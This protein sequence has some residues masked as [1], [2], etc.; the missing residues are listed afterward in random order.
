MTPPPRRPS[1][2]LPRLALLLLPL[3]AALPAAAQPADVGQLQR[4]VESALL[5]LGDRGALGTSDE[6]LTVSSP[7]QVRYEL[8]AVLVP[9]ADGAPAIMAITPGGAAER[10]RLRVG[11]RLVSVNGKALAGVDEPVAALQSAIAADDGALR[12]E[13]LRAGKVQAATGS[14]GI[15]AIP[16][17]RLVVGAATTGACDGYVSDQGAQPR[18]HSIYA[19][20]ITRIDGRSTPLHPTNRHRVEPGRHVLTVRELVDRTWLNRAQVRTIDLMQRRERA[21][22]YKSLVVDVQPGTT[23]KI[24]AR[25]LRDK[26]DSESI[27][28][29]AY[30]EPVVWAVDPD[31]CH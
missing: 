5:A 20:D 25:L 19:A 30:W 31:P 14:A 17:Y 26:L 13:Y 6:P 22:A 28:A 12:V 9:R 24:G 3:F 11:D 18:S 16:A 29:N 27:R 2:S 8:G 7:T 21:R 10:L 15:V 4:D 1:T 23:Y